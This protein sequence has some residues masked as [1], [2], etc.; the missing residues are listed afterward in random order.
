[1]HSFK[2]ALKGDLK[3]YENFMFHPE[4]EER[5]DAVYHVKSKE[6]V[7]KEKDEERFRREIAYSMGGRILPL[8]SKVIRK[9]LSAILETY[10][11]SY[12]T[13]RGLKIVKPKALPNLFSLDG[14]FSVI[15]TG[16]GGIE[17]VLDVEVICS[18]R[19]IRRLLERYLNSK[20]FC[21]QMDEETKIIQDYLDNDARAF[22]KASS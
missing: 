2:Q 8:I 4:L 3:L 15:D 6:T 22:Q 14:K 12:E 18:S 1:M 9:D 13:H 16:N 20:E 17:R 21:N 19:I 10:D 7:Y 11:Y 5:T